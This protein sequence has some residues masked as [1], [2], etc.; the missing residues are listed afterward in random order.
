MPENNNLVDIFNNLK[1]SLLGT[2]SSKIDS[3]IDSSLQSIEKYSSKIG[4]NKFVD[5]LKSLVSSIGGGNPFSLVRDFQSANNIEMYDQTGRISRYREYDAIL[6]KISYCQRALKVIT[7][8]II[9]PDDIT[10]RSIVFVRDEESTKSKTQK[11]EDETIIRLKQIEKAINCDRI[12]HKIIYKT[13]KKGD[14]FTEIIYSPKGEN[15]FT[16][17]QESINNEFSFKI[18]GLV[19]MRQMGKKISQTIVLQSKDKKEEQKNVNINVV[20][21]YGDFG[22]TLQGMT[23][24]TMGLAFSTGSSGSISTHVPLATV[25]PISKDK[26]AAGGVDVNKFKSK[27]N[28]DDEK[29]KE[30]KK[31]E[32]RD[33]FVSQHDPKYVIRLETERFRTCLGFLIF[34]KINLTAASMGSYSIGRNAVDALC[35]DIL[36]QLKTSLQLNKVPDE[37]AYSVELKDLLLN[38]IRTIQDNKDLRIRYVPPEKMVHWRINV[39]KYYP[40]GESILD[41]VAFDCK[42]LI[43]LKTATT[44]KRL[45]NATDKRIISVETGLPRDAKNLIEMLRE[46]MRKRKISVD[47]FGSVDSIP[48]Q[49]STFEDIYIPMRDGK[50][51]VEFD[52]VQFGQNPNEDIEGLKFIRDNIVADLGVPAP[53]LGLEENTSNRALLSVENII[54]CRTIISFQKEMSSPLR[55][56][57]LKIYNMLYPGDV[58]SDLNGVR[59]TYPEP[60]ISPYEH[61]MEYVEQMQRLM[62]VYRALGIPDT[63]LKKKYL[64]SIDWD[65]IEKYKAEDTINTELGDTGG[66]DQN[67]MGGGGMGMYPPTSGMGMY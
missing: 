12:I 59:I 22:G 3:E 28:D 45:T 4:T 23:P 14:N 2:K 31:I 55:E 10:K 42:L 30:Q 36:N 32:I 25:E 61:E 9:S 5:T 24:S 7:D 13:L 15:A 17:L 65:E 40:Y 11:K 29:E 6:S 58:Q 57:F 48:S 33:I 64:P 50:K 35:I 38:Y 1:T 21:E 20:L 66:Q 34:P 54:F 44:I 18:D 37:I 53:Y 47:S 19:N 46:D 43:A 26:H 60:K 39:D 27:F 56:L 16:I 62:E 49:I 63:Y 8:N 41:V 51:F 52:Q 67:A